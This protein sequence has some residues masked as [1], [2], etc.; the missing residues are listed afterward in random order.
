MR[1]WN[2]WGDEATLV[3]LPAHGAAFLQQLIG[4]GQ[5]LPDASFDQVLAQVPTSRLPAHPLI[6]R[7]AADRLRHARG[8]SLP[9]WLALRSGEFEVFPDGVAFPQTPAQIRELLEWA[10]AQEAV[11]IPYGGGTS[12]AGH[13]NPQPGRRPVLTVS[14]ARM[15]QLLELDRD[16]QIATFGPGANGPQV[17]SQ[18]RA[19]GY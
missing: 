7:E 10:A 8:Q 13:I 14:L 17:E 6:S 2:G 15:N 5:R 16:S 9:D 4:P 1:R 3:E 19:H 12:V 18:L 11:V